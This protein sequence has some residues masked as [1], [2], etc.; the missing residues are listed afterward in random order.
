[1]LSILR[2]EPQGAH[3]GGAPLGDRGP[4]AVVEVGRCPIRRDLD[5][6]VLASCVGV[7]RLL[8]FRV[9]W[10]TLHHERRP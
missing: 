4:A 3:V 9:E 6:L 8:A 5:G 2:S 1:M 10:S 7:S